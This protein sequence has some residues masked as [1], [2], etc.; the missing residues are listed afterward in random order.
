MASAPGR[1]ANELTPAR[2]GL[3][4]RRRTP[5]ARTEFLR[6]TVTAPVAGRLASDGSRP[7]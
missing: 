1:S 4:Q 7:D 6:L 2:A 3:M 5:L